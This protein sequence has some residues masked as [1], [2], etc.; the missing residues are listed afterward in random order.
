MELSHQSEQVKKKSMCG[1]AGIFDLNRPPRLD[2]VKPMVD[3]LSHRGPDA[4]GFLVQGPVA[5]GMRRLSIIDLAGGDQPIFNEDRSIAVIMNGELFNY[6]EL[7]EWLISKGHR[8]STKSDTE[9]IVHLYEEY[10]LGLLPKLNGMFAFALWDA[11]SHSFLLARDR[12]GVKPLY[13]ARV[14]SRWFF[15]S[16]LKSLLTQPELDTTLDP[17]SLADYLRL[18]Y[19]PRDASPYARVKKLL[20][21]HYLSLRDS[22]I[23]DRAWWD[24]SALA[25]S[26]KKID[27]DAEASLEA[28]FDD[29]VRLRM[30]SDVPVAS[31]LSGG[32]DS[33]L[34]T[35]T[36]QRESAVP[37][38]TFAMGFE[39]SEFNELP[40]ASSVARQAGTQH[41]ELSASVADAVEKL[42]LLLWHMD[43][44]IGD[45]S[46][47]PNYLISS[48]AAQHVKVCLS[49]LGGDELFGGYSRYL[50]PGAGRIRKVFQ[51]APALARTL[52]PI[53]DR[54]NYAWAEEFRLAGDPSMAWR[55]YLHKLQI[56]DTRALENLGFPAIGRAE[57][58]IADLWSKFPGDDSI[59]RRQFIDQQTYLPDQILAITDRMS[60]AASLEVRVPFMDYRLVRFSQRVPGS[61]KQNPGEFKILLKK[62]LG[63]RCPP[64]ILTRPKWGFDTPLRFWVQ[65]PGLYDLIRGLPE[66]QAVKQGLFKADAVRALVQDSQTAG[67]N[68][69]R[70]WNLFVLDVWLQ[71]HNR[72]AP[73]KETL[74]ELLGAYV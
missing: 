35:L 26:P 44:P 42:P 16:E 58:T 17:D 53:V 66:G 72:P 49:G 41:S 27:A 23:E 33:S 47:I 63:R 69:R 1:I 43:E 7:R 38:R 73:P 4:D 37:M 51:H 70:V 8:F 32:L 57:Q 28:E 67:R 19:I 60:M 55:T 14:G 59:S 18:S 15:S 62:V 24:L 68:A 45:S 64:E 61:L 65:Q 11:K 56:L 48:M 31:F 6:V 2:E 54:H 22:R 46:I 74:S 50:D 5:M 30:R 10:G 9:I 3:I 12:M 40:Y 34:I 71:V 36:A 29:A 13:Y 52:A 20:P 25:S 21:G 39:H